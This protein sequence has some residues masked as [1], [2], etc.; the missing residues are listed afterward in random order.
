MKQRYEK[1]FLSL[2]QQAH[3]LRDDGLDI[4]EPEDAVKILQR[5]GYYRL[6]G[7]WFM[8]REL[9]DP[10]YII[11]KDAHGKTKR[12]EKRKSRF[13]PGTTLRQ[14]CS[15]YEFDVEL[16]QRILSALE[17]IEIALRFQVGHTLGRVAAFAHRDPKNLR[18]D[19]SGSDTS[20]MAL[21]YSKWLKSGHADLT[22]AMDL[23]EERSS[24]TFVDHFRHKYGGPLPVWAATEIMTFGTLTR[25]YAGLKLRDQ[26][27]IAGSLGVLTSAESGNGPLFN[28][29]L[30]HLRYIR[31]VCAHYGRLWNKNMTVQIADSSDIS[32]L[33]HLGASTAT[34]ERIYG[35]LVVLAFLLTRVDP[36]DR[37]RLD[38]VQFINDSVEKSGISVA[39]MGFPENWHNEELWHPEYRGNNSDWG[40]K[41][42]KLDE[43]KAISPSEAG[44]L[45]RP[46]VS[47]KKRLD[48]LRYLRKRGMLIGVYF[49]QSYWYP[50]FQFRKDN[51]D[52]QPDIVIKNQELF[53]SLR[54]SCSP[55]EIGWVMA[56]Y[57][58]EIPEGSQRVTRID[59]L[60]NQIDE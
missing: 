17:T 26:N 43:L 51:G 38:I 44:E 7:Y 6:S 58:L 21:Q 12:L 42:L 37:W 1:K 23:E 24:E 53:S 55:E 25:L 9:D 46:N 60:G 5:C 19:F 36:D 14:V 41:R 29:W 49:D 34:T 50:A 59:V 27:R 40:L 31:N 56:N 48:Y 35:T 20:V 57:W 11:I 8:F 45:L 54:G 18:A 33:S 13:R 47:S 10:D 32:E 39:S 15:I 4:G 28:N 16:R 3:K 52:L 22:Q 2:A 30:N